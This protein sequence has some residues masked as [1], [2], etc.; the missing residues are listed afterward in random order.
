MVMTT[1]T[2][3]RNSMIIPVNVTVQRSIPVLTETQPT[4]AGIVRPALQGLR[5]QSG[6]EGLQGLRDFP[7]CVDQQAPEDPRVSPV[8]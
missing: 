4:V 6:Q 3:A 2:A 8:R 5:G 7:V 1:G